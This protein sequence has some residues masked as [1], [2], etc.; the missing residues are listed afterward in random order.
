M[1]VGG[2]IVPETN[3]TR[4]EVHRP[5][6][7]HVAVMSTP[8]SWAARRMVEPG[9]TDSTT[10]SGRMISGML[11]RASGYHR[12]LPSERTLAST[13]RGTLPQA[14][15]L[16]AADVR[17]RLS[18]FCDSMLDYRNATRRTAPGSG[19]KTPDER[20]TLRS[21]VKCCDTPSTDSCGWFRPCWRWRSS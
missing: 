11:M 15:Q 6:P 14:W 9:S 10:R 18:D 4:H 1:M 7:P 3:F 16:L 20:L 2:G 17:Y 8:P 12:D 13:W 19:R 21:H 5:R